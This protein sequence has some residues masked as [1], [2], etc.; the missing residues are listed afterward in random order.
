MA[1][2]VQP[3]D[4]EIEFTPDIKACEWELRVA[5]GKPLI[6]AAN[7]VVDNFQNIIINPIVMGGKGWKAL[8]QTSSWKWM[9]STKGFG[10]LG[11]SN[12]M[13]P[14]KLIHAILA[15][16]E[17]KPII[18]FDPNNENVAIG[19]YFKFADIDK[20]RKATT[21]PAAGQL[22]LPSDASWFD[23]VYKGIALTENGFHFRRTGP[24][25]GSR[26]SVI[27]GPDAGLMKKGGLWQVTPRFKLD[28]DRLI[29]MNEDKIAITIQYWMQEFLA[30]ETRS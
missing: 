25:R 22:N 23:W 26:S 12:V 13:E 4:I 21:H 28:L 8:V 19:F 10:E 5:L 15:S 24:T 27:A 30:G 11:F 18:K 3:T 29:E 9:N 6:N 7:F 17:C 1:K 2:K 16:W 14:W 20:L